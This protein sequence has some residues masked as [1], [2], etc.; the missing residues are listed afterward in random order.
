LILGGV[1]RRSITLHT[2]SRASQLLSQLVALA[3]SFAALVSAG[4]DWQ[5]QDGQRR[6]PFTIPAGGKVGFTEMAVA[7]TGIT[8]TN[9]LS[10]ERSLTNQ[11]FLN[12]SGVAAGDIDGDGLCDLYFCGLDSPNALYRNLGNWKFE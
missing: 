10:E 5:L 11:I 6:A 1:H 8:F 4:I 12:G 9:R 2:V 3:T 7:I